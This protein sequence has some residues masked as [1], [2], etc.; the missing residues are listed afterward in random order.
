[1]TQ[2]MKNKEFILEYFNA[3]SGKEKPDEILNHYI[4][5]QG[6]I[7]HIK[8]FESAF[9]KYEAQLEE[10]VSEG[11]QLIVRARLIGKH[12]GEFGGVPPTH[13]HV[14]VPFVVSYIIENN[15]IVSH[16]LIADQMVMMEQLGA[17]GQD[18]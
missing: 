13:R 5:D 8:F 3:L 2:S 16:W 6:L 17:V 12:E 1:M 15:K 4:A 9:P 14:D 10:L 11:N 18:V 7:E